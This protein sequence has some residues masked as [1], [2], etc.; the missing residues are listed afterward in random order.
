MNRV[1]NEA[2]E[3]FILRDGDFELITPEEME[4]LKTED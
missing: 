1:M 3:R 2:Q 4:E